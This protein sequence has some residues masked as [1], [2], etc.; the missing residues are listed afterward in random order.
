MAIRWR[1]GKFSDFDPQ[2]MQE[3]EAAVVLAG[4]P[5]AKD[6]KSIYI[7]FAPGTVKRMATY[8]DMRENME[9]SSGEIIGEKLSELCG[10]AV[11]ECR[12]ATG[13]AETATQEALNAAASANGAATEAENAAARANAAAGACEQLADGARVA[14]LEEKMEKVVAALKNVLSTE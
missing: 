12:E 6:G 11:Q 9:N 4:D 8:E 13:Q 3:G 10:E 14:A 5:Q 2:K 7:A 1:R